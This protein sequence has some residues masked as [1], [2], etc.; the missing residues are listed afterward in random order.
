[1]PSPHNGV[2]SDR[3][4][5]SPVVRGISA[6]RPAAFDTPWWGASRSVVEVSLNLQTTHGRI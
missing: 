3:A 2:G 4:R 5:Y 1:M 6:D